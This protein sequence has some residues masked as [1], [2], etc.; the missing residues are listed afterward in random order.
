VIRDTSIEAYKAITENGML[1]DR[2]WRVYDILFHNGPLI[3]ARVAELYYFQ[4][5]RTS[6]SETIRNRLTELRDMG[7]VRETGKTFDPNTGMTVI[8][9]DVTS[10]LPVTFVKQKTKTQI[11]RELEA[12]V[13]ELEREN[14]E[15]RNK[16]SNVELNE[17]Y[18][19]DSIRDKLGGDVC[20]RETKIDY[21]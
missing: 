1:S 16:Q 8:V 3:G 20:Q 5:G 21:P 7:V 17:Q 2:R 18:I 12:R 6:A 10:K 11:I 15:L 13:A 9:W 4:Y 14:H 19:N